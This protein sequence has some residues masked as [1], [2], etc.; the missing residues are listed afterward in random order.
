VN[1]MVGQGAIRLLVVGGTGFIGSHIVKHAIGLGWRV[2]SLSKHATHKFPKDVQCITADIVDAD[3]LMGALGDAQF[4]YVVNCGGYINHAFY[5]DGGRGVIDAHFNGMLNLVNCLDREVLRS[6]INI[7]SSDE[8]GS[9]SAP[10]KEKS[11]EMPISPYSFAKVATAHFLQMLWRTEQFPAVTLRLFLTYGPGQDMKRF[12]PQVILGC[13]KGLAFPTSEGCQLR[14]FCFVQDTVN[15]IFLALDNP[16]ACGEV[17]NVG[18]GQPVSIH[19]MIERVKEKVG[20]GVP[21]FGRVP[22]RQGENMALYA[23]ISKS[24]EILMWEPKVTLDA[25]LDKTIQW[26]TDQL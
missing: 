18:S 1:V 19:Q 13:L 4:E 8:Y 22:Y 14:D 12:F 10:Q 21:E 26:V 2:T 20:S 7:G 15:A 17:I 3:F 25:G 23:D 6:F 5:F 9:L 16:A 24:K 11:R